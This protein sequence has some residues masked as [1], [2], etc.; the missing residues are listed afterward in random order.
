MIDPSGQDGSAII[1]GVGSPKTIAL[2]QNSLSKTF[3]PASQSV[4]K[5]L[6][7]KEEENFHGWKE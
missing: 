1:R 4:R 5:K 3:Q 2:M 6:K 7:K